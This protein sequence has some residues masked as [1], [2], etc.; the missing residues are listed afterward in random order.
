MIVLRW[1]REALH[2]SVLALCIRKRVTIKG[3]WKEL[4]FIFYMFCF[5]VFKWVN[6]ADVFPV[7]SLF[8]AAWDMG[9]R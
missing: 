7:V 3:F 6:L 5:G 8:P 9:G 1:K 4:Q 2:N